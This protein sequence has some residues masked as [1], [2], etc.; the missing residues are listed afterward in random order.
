M[1]IVRWAPF[2]LA[3]ENLDDLVRR[4]FGDYGSSLLASRTGWTP[5]LEAFIDGNQ[6]HV[7]VEVPGIDPSAV[8]IEFEDGVLS[9][10]GERRQE[11]RPTQ[12]G[13]FR[14]EMRHGAF[15]RRI[16]LPDGVDHEQIRATYDAGILDVTV[17]MP[18]K[19][20]RKVKVEIG[21]NGA[22]DSE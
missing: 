17:P 6:L 8:D 19:P 2:D 9:I 21:A 1:A 13:W 4:T 14:S 18:E 16:S 15:E 12:E 10:S 11:S 3:S 20:R 5:P 22:P 7:R